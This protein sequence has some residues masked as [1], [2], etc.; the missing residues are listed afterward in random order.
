MG[1]TTP[2]DTE[3]RYVDAGG[4]TVTTSLRQLDLERAST[5]LPVRRLKSHARQRHYSGLFWSVTT[6]GTTRALTLAGVAL[7]ALTGC[8]TQEDPTATADAPS[9]PGTQVQSRDRAE[10]LGITDPPEVA[11]VRETT[12]E[13]YQQVFASCLDE[14]GW[15]PTLH[16]DGTIEV[17]PFTHE[18]EEAYNLA[19]YVCG[20]QYP[21]ADIYTTELTQEQHRMVYEYTREEFIPCVEGLGLHPGALPGLEA[22]LADPSQ[23]WMG[24]M[25]GQLKQ[26]VSDGRI[27][28]PNEWLVRCPPRPPS[29]VLYGAS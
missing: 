16:P 13:E 10:A 14:A 11:V 24:D 12:P 2:P 4:V 29:D 21:V 8:T 26:A 28:Y 18:Q 27:E 25:T 3:V 7:A 23:D 22:Y 1:A 6:G 20:E 19:V 15:N 17:G 5:A 9:S